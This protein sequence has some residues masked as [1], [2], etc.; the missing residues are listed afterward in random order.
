MD[1]LKVGYRKNFGMKRVNLA[2]SSRLLPILF[3]F[4]FCISGCASIAISALGAS[5]GLGIPYVF[6][7]CADR[8]V[9]F[10]LEQVNRVTPDV[11]KRMDI[12]VHARTWTQS[13]ET[14]L[15]SADEVDILIEMQRV[16]N[17]ATRI[18]VDAKKSQFL[19]D[20]A[21]AEEI[22]NQLEMTLAK[23]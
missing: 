20:K 15:A 8:T 13:G 14:I 10:P 23:K 9:N 16:T 6:S 17:K 22:I 21:T 12:V 11:L 18:T 2:E 19:R 5:A 1:R 7:N 4:L 3:L